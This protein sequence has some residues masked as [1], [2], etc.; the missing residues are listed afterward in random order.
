VGV[1]A[2][3]LLPSGLI[4]DR[5]MFS[6]HSSGQVSITRGNK[7]YTATYRVDKA[8]MTLKS[9]WG[10]RTTYVGGAYSAQA[11]ILLSEIV[12]DSKA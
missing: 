9:A 5:R 10:S 2:C 11:R 6:K 7:T 3:R 4:R 8:V 12:A 1:L